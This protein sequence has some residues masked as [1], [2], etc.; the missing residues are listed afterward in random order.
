M[1]MYQDGVEVLIILGHCEADDENR[2]VEE[3]PYC[4]R[5]NETC[6]GDCPYYSEEN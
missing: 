3:L 4:P 1:E 2:N 5:F 6:S